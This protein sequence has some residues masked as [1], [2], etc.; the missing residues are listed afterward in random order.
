MTV[1]TV[2][3]LNYTDIRF[4]A[5]SF[6]AVMTTVYKM[7]NVT[8]SVKVKCVLPLSVCGGGDPKTIFIFLILLYLTTFIEV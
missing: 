2:A 8:L 1:K 7:Y 6:P 4:L 5:V 3:V